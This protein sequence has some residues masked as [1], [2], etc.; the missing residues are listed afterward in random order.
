MDVDVQ[1]LNSKG[2]GL[3]ALQERAHRIRAVLDIRAHPGHG[4]CIGVRW[5]L[6]NYQ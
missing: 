3:I 4:A 1:L 2:R 6:D 5:A